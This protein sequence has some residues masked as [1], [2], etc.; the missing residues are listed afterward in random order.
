MQR[1]HT[2]GELRKENS[3]ENITLSGWVLKYRNLGG[4]LFIDL[5]DRYGVTQVIF[6]PA[7]LSAEV[8]EEAAKIRNEF[9]ITATGTVQVKPQPNKKLATGEIEVLVSE[10]K[11]ENSATTPPF[12]F[13]DGKS[14]ANDELRLK[15]R[16]LD[17]R[18]AH[19]MQ[20]LITRNK[21]VHSGRDYFQKNNFLE[22]ET[23]ILVKSTPEGA[24][25]FLVPSRINQGQ[26]YALP[27]SPQLYKQLLM[28]AG[29]DRYYQ[30]AR[31]MRDEDLRA[32]RQPEHTQF[33]FEMSFV[34]ADD[35]RSFTEGLMQHIFKETKGIELQT[36]FTTFTYAEAMSRFGSDKPD[37]RFGLE[38]NDL[39][40]KARELDF[41]VF[42]KAERVYA[43]F[44]P[45][46]QYSRKQ[47]D[48][49]TKFVGKYK[50]KG[51]AFVKL[52]NGEYEGGVTKF[53]TDDFKAE[54]K[55][56][57]GDT[58]N[59][60]FFFGADKQR[61]VQTYLGHLRNLLARELE[62][63]DKNEFKF[64]WVNDFPLFAYNEEEEKWETEHHMFSMPKEEFIADF[65]QRPGEVIGDLWDL[66]LNGW[67]MGSGS[68]RVNNPEIQERIMNFVGINKE[69]A[70][71]KFGFLLDAYQYGAPKHGGMGIGVD[72]LVSLM[73]GIEDIR[74]VIAFP[75]NTN[76][77][78]TMDGSP[79]QIDEDQLREL[80]V[81]LK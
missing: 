16:Y 49:Y 66:C 1:T 68:I 33:D 29:T 27:Q 36:P 58:E 32:D 42:A 12:N 57:S 5:R 15:Y 38:L 8:M 50:A 14:D 64:C 18:S 10:F 56:I 39:T 4:L 2:C 40:A 37:I 62:L 17:I 48:K 23:P 77:Q 65:E 20:N 9:V 60:T 46:E 67:E 54:M 80:G 26:F 34:N 21:M 53:L 71:E 78:C 72:R 35:I 43:L 51:L 45:N 55:K 25:D 24:R 59:G 81:K 69:A 13:K 3:G 73:L 11:L 6:D 44:V 7:T 61:T 31:C 74:E 30:V 63:F 70:H 52:N 19:M 47:I 22:I 28:I 79:S 75:K 41:A 76:A